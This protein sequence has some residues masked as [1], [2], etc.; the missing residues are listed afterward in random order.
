MGGDSLFTHRLRHGA[1]LAAVPTLLAAILAALATAIP[2]QAG[3]DSLY[4][5]PG[6]RPGP[7]ILYRSVAEAPQLTNGRGWRA[8]PILISGASAYRDGEFLYQDFLYDDHGANARPRDPQDPRAGDDTFSEPNGTY[9]YPT[10]DD[11][12]DNA[13]DL[14]ELRV[15]PRGDF[16]VFRITYNTLNDPDLVATTIAI[17]GEQGENQDFPHGANAKAPADLFLTVHGE[18]A[19]LIEAESGDELD[20]APE[21]K[22]DEDRRQV[23]VKVSEEAWNPRRRTVRLAAGTGLWDNDA[24]AYLIPQ[25]SR[26]DSEPGGA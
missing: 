22:V 6:P 26:S 24:D 5:G 10:D 1:P 25:E 13:A 16:T 14:V 11:Y 3:E 18:E 21:V 4:Q 2:A 20:P 8:K 15:E 12:A 9:T 23:E 7:D 19:D 17:G